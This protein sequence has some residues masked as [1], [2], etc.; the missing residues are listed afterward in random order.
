MDC[1]SAFSRNLWRSSDFSYVGGHHAAILPI[2][3]GPF[4]YPDNWLDL[5]DYSNPGYGLAFGDGFAYLL[6]YE[7]IRIVDLRDRDNLRDAG[8]VPIGGSDIAV[9]NAVGYVAAEHEGVV[10]LDL[11]DPELPV[12]TSRVETSRASTIALSEDLLYVADYTGGL[13]VFHR[14]EDGSFS[15]VGVVNLRDPALGVALTHGRVWVSTSTSLF[16][17]QEVVRTVP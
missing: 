3:P 5:P 11:S 2:G 9:Q 15:L 16:S 13:K 8:A 14:S 12:Q 10:V 17:L 4:A 7:D 6:G 1:V